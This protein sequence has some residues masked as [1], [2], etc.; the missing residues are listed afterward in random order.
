MDRLSGRIPRYLQ[1]AGILRQRLATP[2]YQT[3]QRL[4]SEPQLATEFR[5]SRETVRQALGLL[6]EEGSVHAV[7]GRGTFVSPGRKPMGVRITL[8]ISDPYIAGRPSAMRI[9][10]EGFAPC[11]GDVARALGLRTHRPVY[12]YTILRTI[13][14]QPFRYAK[15][16]LP[17]AIAQQLDGD[18]A[19]HLTISERLEREAGLRLIRCTQSVLAIPAPPDAATVLTLP[20][21]ASVLLF[22]RVYFDITG[23]AVEYA[24]DYQDS[25]RFPHEEVLVSSRA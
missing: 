12:L 13:K 8:P 5:V 16:Y 18:G 24:L 17:A 15:V 9:L 19:A 4:P 23:T 7:V 14:R 3:G 11:P 1:I 25:T 10:E 22:R 6:R 2:A 21:G 20:P